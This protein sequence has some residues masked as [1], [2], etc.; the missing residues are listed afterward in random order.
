MDPG[1]G[2]A[3]EHQVGQWRQHEAVGAEVGTEHAFGLEWQLVHRQAT[4]QVARQLRGGQFPQPAPEFVEHAHAHVVRGDPALQHPVARGGDGQGLAQE[5]AHL[6][7][8]DAAVL[9]LRDEVEVVG[10]RLLHPEDVV[11]QHRLA[12]GGGEAFVGQP[13]RADQYAAQLADLG[14]HPEAGRA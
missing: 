13:G 12:V 4:H 2:V 7:H 1:A 11:E 9:H 14:M 6:Q 10:A 5:L 8:L 3:G